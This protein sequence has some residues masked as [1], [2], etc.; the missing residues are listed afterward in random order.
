MSYPCIETQ[1]ASYASQ[2]S[3]VHDGKKMQAIKT[4]NFSK[5]RDGVGL[6]VDLVRK[7]LL[8]EVDGRD[9]ARVLALEASDRYEAHCVSIQSGSEF[10]ENKFLHANFNKTSF[11]DQVRAKWLDTTLT[12]HKKVL[13]RTFLSK[14]LDT[15]LTAHK[16]VLYSQIVMDY[17]WIPKGWA[18]QHWT[19][20]LFSENLPGFH[21]LLRP[22]GSVY[23]PFKAHCLNRI[24]CNLPKLSALYD[25]SFLRRWELGEIALWRHTQDVDPWV[26]EEVFRK[27]IDQEDL[28]CEIDERELDGS[29]KV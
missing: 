14:W 23:F 25:I 15:T 1:L 29:D 3:L 28:Y 26:M 7:K 19:E 24:C 6:V 5:G 27:R 16:K 22:S 17:F 13:Y 18:E 4:N 20:K 8:N 10:D 2:H 21:S 11:T 9:L 12:A